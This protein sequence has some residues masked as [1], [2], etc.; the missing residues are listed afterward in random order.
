MSGVAATPRAVQLAR[1][2]PQVEALFRSAPRELLAQI[3]QGVLH[4][5]PRPARR[6]TSV[7]TNLGGELYGPLRRGVGGPGG[8]VILD[9]PEL[10]LGSRPDILVPDLAGW[11]RVR[12]PD[13]IGPDDAP[14]YYDLAP[15]WVCEVLS[16]DTEA[17]DRRDKMTVYAREGVAWPWLVDPETQTL[18]VYR[19]ERGALR[20]S[21]RHRGDVR[22]RIQPFDA[23]ELDLAALWE[24]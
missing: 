7:A 1:N 19:L 14:P 13:A 2:D 11:R 20:E 9:E 21:A 3:I 23:V 18:E 16:P 8:W 5:S 10:H 17:I 4:V 12:M 15:G 22:A 24:R 6:H